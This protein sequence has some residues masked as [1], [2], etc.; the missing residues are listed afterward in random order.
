MGICNVNTCCRDYEAII[1]NENY[2]F[3]FEDTNIYKIKEQLVLKN[4]KSID[5]DQLLLGKEY[6]KIINKI[7]ENPTDYIK[8][9]KSHNLFDTFIKIKPCEP[10]QYSENNIFDIISY[11]MESQEQISI[12]EKQNEIKYMINNGNVADI[13]LLD[14]ISIGNDIKENFWFFLEENEE[15]RQKIFSSKYEYLMIICLPKENEKTNISFI[16]YNI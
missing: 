3:G 2:H 16:F 14:T 15:Y 5:S 6:F 12:I 11:L 9:S 7:R 4:G 10:L 1:T 8:E 13:C